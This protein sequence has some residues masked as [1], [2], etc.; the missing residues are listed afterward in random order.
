MFPVKNEAAVVS[1]QR[2]RTACRLKCQM[3]YPDQVGNVEMSAPVIQQKATEMCCGNSGGVGVGLG[4]VGLGGV[5]W[6]CSKEDFFSSIKL[7]QQRFCWVALS[8]C[9]SVKCDFYFLF[10]TLCKCVHN[11]WSPNLEQDWTMTYWSSAAAKYENFEEQSL[12]YATA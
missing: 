9:V 2:A 12:N 10:Q 8:D 1:W 7:R 4:G 11:V 3:I 5:G 6:G